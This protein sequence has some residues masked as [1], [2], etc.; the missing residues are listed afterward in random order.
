M[1]TETAI[2]TVADKVDLV[3]TTLA[4][5]MGVAT[6]YFYP[7]LVKQQIINGYINLSFAALSLIAVGFFIFLGHWM[8]TDN[9][10][11]EDYVGWAY[12]GGIVFATMFM[13]QSYAGLVSIINPEYYALQEIAHLVK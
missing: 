13:G 3:V 9:S 6:D 5:K 7:I 4:T 10:A 12:F 11:D 2:Q 1:N 8:H